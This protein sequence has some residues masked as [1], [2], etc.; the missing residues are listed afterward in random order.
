M[1]DA[2]SGMDSS[3]AHALAVLMSHDI[4]ALTDVTGFGLAGHLG[5]MLRASGVGV[6]LEL[7]AVPCYSG[8]VHALTVAPSSLQQANELALQDYTLQGSLRPDDA[9]LRLLADPQTSGGLLAAIAAD[10]MQNCLTR[11][12][13]GGYQAAVI[14]EVTADGW[15]IA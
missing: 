2:L 1:H 5:E 14:G 9:R 12:R 13:E 8:A 4:H 3:N 11:L 7:S 6:S 10:Q 15:K